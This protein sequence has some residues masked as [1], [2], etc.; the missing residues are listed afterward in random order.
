MGERL[1]ANRKWKMRILIGVYELQSF[2]GG[3][4]TW[5]LTMF[6]A[7]RKLG[8]SVYIYTHFHRVNTMFKYLPVVKDGKYDLIICNSNAV[9]DDLK[10][11]EGKKVFVSH[12]VIP[13]LEQPI[14]GADTYVAVAEDS[15]EN[16][17]KKGFEIYVIIRNPI[18]IDRFN[19][20]GCGERLKTIGFFNKENK[21]FFK[22]EL[23]AMGF[24]IIEVGRNLTFV[25]EEFIA[26]ADLIVASG[27][28][29]YEAMAM[30]K[31]VVI[32]GTNDQTS[33]IGIMD[34]FVDDEAFFKFRQS[35]C[36][37]RYNEI[38][39]HFFSSLK[40][41]VEKYEQKQ[42]EKNRELIVQ[43]NNYMNIAKM[44]IALV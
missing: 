13:Q 15:A 32:V 9:L 8:H 42:G 34:G 41:E 31:N 1:R 3:T 35:N 21:T 18:D 24:D 5:T 29:A 44:F 36:T 37:G 12:G 2:W 39:L 16:C 20:V 11:L 23:E 30:G 19:Y 40:K 14:E 38:Y 7:F 27:R 43:H 6:K 10:K 33:Q 26:Q 28:C 4:Q 25:V 17:E 22:K